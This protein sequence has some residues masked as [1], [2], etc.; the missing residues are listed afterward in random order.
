MTA[1]ERRL[2]RESIIL[3]LSRNWQQVG[4]QIAQQALAATT[5]TPEEMAKVS[6]WVQRRKNIR[7]LYRKMLRYW[8]ANIDSILDTGYTDGGTL[9]EEI[10]RRAGLRPLVK[11]S[12]SVQTRTVG[13]I[14][15]DTV[16]T[17]A[18]AADA[19]Q[20]NIERLFRVTQQRAISEVEVN[21]A[22]A[23]GLIEGGAPGHLRS[24]LE[25]DLRK[26]IGEGRVL[27]INGRKYDPGKYAELVARTRT[28][29]ANSL[30]TI[31]TMRRYG[32][33]LVQVSDHDTETALCNQYEGKIYSVSGTS[34]QYPALTDYPPYHPN[35]LH[36]L[37][38]YIP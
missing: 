13:V 38:P 29:E 14:A 17:M 25:K 6:Y 18:T 5:E 19:G 1:E 36:V 34:K 23:R 32:Q 2:L 15:E 10:F 9:A 20:R 11:E 26:A 28:R 4:N 22:L 33:D 35:C 31:Q 24:Q 7:E 21:R 27:E 37:T 30:G 3:E 16:A 12:L 8:G